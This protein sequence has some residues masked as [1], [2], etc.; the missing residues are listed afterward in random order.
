MNADVQRRTAGI[1]I[2]VV[3]AVYLLHAAS[4]WPQI[5]DDA[6]ITFRYARNLVLGRGPYYN[7]GEHV[8]GYTNF[9]MMLL[10]A[11]AIRLSGPDDVL[12]WAK[13]IGVAA[14]VAGVL[15]TIAL[16]GRWLRSIDRLRAAA[17]VVA[18]LAGLLVAID[19][20]FALYSTSGLETTLFAA[21]MALALLLADRSIER[22]RWQG[23][24]AALALAGLTRPEAIA[25]APAVLLAMGLARRERRFLIR[26]IVP[27]AAIVLVVFVA[28]AVFRYVVYDGDLL[29]NTFYAKAGGIGWKLSSTQYLLGFAVRHLLGVLPL[30]VAA[31]PLLI[32]SPLRW[33]LV[34]ALAVVLTGMVAIY[35]GGPDWMPAYRL[36]VVYLPAVAALAMLSIAAL[37]ARLPGSDRRVLMA[38]GLV[39]VLV[40]IWQWPSDRAYRAFVLTRTRGYLNGHAA[41]AGW[42]AE[43]ARPGETVALMDIGLV[44]YRCIDLRILDITG[45]TDRTIA[46]SPGGFLDKRFDPA[47]VFDQRP[48]FLVIVL[49]NRPGAPAGQLALTP[50]TT[51]EDRLV[52]APQF[53]ARYVR[54]PASAPAAGDLLERVRALSGAAAVFSHDYPGR[55]YLLAVFERQEP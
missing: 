46:R 39:V 26:C 2:A 24:A 14:G 43:R 15:S 7:P 22:G 37:A 6:F 55:L 10:A 41:L 18:P 51:I 3:L 40:A 54:Q 23:V 32:P 28:H 27:D 34:P 52:A 25:L 53:R 20:G 13:L 44:G 42:L 35:I 21:W 49:T 29:P 19:A 36:C 11:G 4:F 16:T 33:R 9:L 30:A 38:C 48:R 5:N 31:A 12:F 1:L 17:P 47:Y 45:L 50:W 8:E